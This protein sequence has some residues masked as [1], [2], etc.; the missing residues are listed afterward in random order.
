MAEQN[1]NSELAKALQ[2][3]KSKARDG[4][5]KGTD[6]DRGIR[7][8]LQNAG[9][10]SDIIRGWYLLT[11]PGFAGTS[12]AWFG[13]FWGFLKLYLT[14]R[15]NEEYCLSAESSLELLTADGKISKQ[16]TIITIAASNQTVELPHSTSILIYSDPKG[17]PN[18][19]I[20]H[21][22][23]NTMPIPIALSRSVSTFYKNS[24]LTAEI[25]LKLIPSASDISR[26]LVEEKA[27]ASAG[28]IAGAYK[29][30]GDEQKSKQIIDDMSAAGFQTDIENP[31]KSELPFLKAG[32]IHSPYAGRIQAMW[33]SMRKPIIELFPDEPGV[34]KDA[35]KT[36]KVIKDLY[37]QDA[38]HSLSIEGYQ[39]TD[40]L[41]DKIAKGEW[42][43]NSDETDRNLTDALAA[44]G[45]SHTFD[46]VLGSIVKVILKNR[47]PGTVFEEDLQIWFREL[48]TPVAQAGLLR[49]SDLTGYRNTP[50]YIEG[51][52]HV[53]PG[54]HAVQDS[55]EAL[56]KLLKDEEHNSVR[57]VLGHFIFVYI[58]PYS[59]GNGRI[60]RFLL[61]LML[62]AGGYSWTVIRTN[63][64]SEYMKALES[65]SIDSN[66]VPFTKLVLSEMKYWKSI[67][68]EN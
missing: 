4:I 3:A 42:D 45:Y 58:H 57:A 37:K 24:S 35:Q 19:I 59:D 54:S 56:F 68:K 47:N 65:A 18:Q 5:L 55:M 2:L 44:K 43:P 64:R 41:I 25:A 10:L 48:F 32:R 67:E 31:F 39:V 22:G 66:I 46:K 34:A 49:Q 13:G 21:N 38:Y 50:V 26:I 53:P 7:E 23:I 11:K 1:N 15:F 28:R 12:T 6:L 29:H 61:N 40:E 30:L 20:K 16:L 9:C 36:L 51:S 52:R 17:F 63:S 62:I 14:E 27:L 60:G 33:A 8:R